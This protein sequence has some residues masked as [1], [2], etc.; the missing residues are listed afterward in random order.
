MSSASSRLFCGTWNVNGQH[1]MQRMDKFILS[2]SEA[3]DIVAIGYVG[4]GK[5]ASDVSR[6]VV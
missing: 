5:R 4:F 3:A 2:D 6:L 1:P